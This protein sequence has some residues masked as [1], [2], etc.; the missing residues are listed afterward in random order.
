MSR[1]RKLKGMQK[2]DIFESFVPN[3]ESLVFDGKKWIPRDR[4]E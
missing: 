2:G 4:R 1:P 3:N